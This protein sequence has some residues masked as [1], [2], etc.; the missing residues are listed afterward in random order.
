MKKFLAVF[1][2]AVMLLSLVACGAKTEAPAADTEAADGGEHF[3]GIIFPTTQNDRWQIESGIIK[4]G[5]EAKGIKAEIQFG[6]DDA[7]TQIKQAEN[8]LS[9]G[10]DMLVVCA[11]DTVSAAQ[12]VEMAHEEEV[13][14]FAYCRLIENCDLDGFVAEDNDSCGTLQ[15]QYLVDHLD[16]GNIIVLGGSPTDSNG[17]LY[18]QRGLEAIQAK[19]DSGDY[20]IVADQMCDGWA[21]TAAMEHTENALTACNN[22]VQ[23]ILCAY[24]GMSGGAVAALKAQG[25]DG[26]VIITGSDGELSAVKRIMDGTQTMTLFKDPRKIAGSAAE[27]IATYITG[28]TPDYNTEQFNGK[29]NVPSV[30]VENQ[31]VDQSN[32][33]E[34]FVDSG[35]FTMEQIEA[36]E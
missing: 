18:H 4:D 2:A 34:A 28:G 22:D 16:K 24:D 21:A 10:A 33:V 12:I 19:V 32:C 1:F 35:Y 14:V 6:N 27:A 3:V 9:Q 31:V 29:V 8:F 30:L 20:V 5:L 11:V 25:L 36:A 17:I 15:G 13:P 23:G 7:Q 26:K